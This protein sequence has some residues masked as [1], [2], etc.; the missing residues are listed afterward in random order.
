MPDPI[1]IIR[2]NVDRL[3]IEIPPSVIIVAACKTRTVEE[4]TAAFEAGLR[5]FGHN[6]VQE[7]QAMLSQLS[8]NAEWRLI[9]HLQRNKSREAVQLFDRIDSID[10]IRLAQ[11]LEKNCSQQGKILP[12]LIE[13]N[14][15]REENKNGAFPENVEELAEFISQQPHLHLEGLMTM[16]PLAGDPQESR[17]FFVETR[18]L[19]DLISSRNFTNTS[20]RTLSMGMS[21][22][23]PI[24][25]QEGANMI[26]LGTAIFGES[27]KPGKN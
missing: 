2:N 10:S 27:Q 8:L 16:G 4:V 7:A 14:S 18:K 17:P 25:I 1:D 21:N 19:F 22:S 26:R 12:V 5:Y 11:E 9:G 20:M 23:Y 3:L 15:G 24:A 6:Y 13:V